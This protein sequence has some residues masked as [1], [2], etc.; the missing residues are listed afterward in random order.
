MK[1][2][3]NAG[4]FLVMLGFGKKGF[5]YPIKQ[6]LPITLLNRLTFTSTVCTFIVTN[7]FTYM[8]EFLSA[9]ITGHHAMLQG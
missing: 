6:I 3:K 1:A 9:V 5:L 8:E 2:L 7:N 4:S